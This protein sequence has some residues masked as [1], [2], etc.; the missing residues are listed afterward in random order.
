MPFTR[1]RPNRWDGCFAPGPGRHLEARRTGRVPGPGLS[2]M[3]EAK[4]APTRPLD[5][6]ESEAA[7]TALLRGE[8]LVARESPSNSRPVQFLRAT[9]HCLSSSP[10][11]TRRPPRGVFLSI[12]SLISEHSTEQRQRKEALSEASGSDRF[13]ACYVW[14]SFL[15]ANFPRYTERV[16]ASSNSRS[17]LHEEVEM[18]PGASLVVLFVLWS[19]LQIRGLAEEPAA[20]SKIVSVE[21]S[22]TASPLS[23]GSAGSGAGTYRLDTVPGT[24]AWHVLDQKQ[25]PGGNGAQAAGFRDATGRGRFAGGI[26]RKGSGHSSEGQQGQP[27][28]AVGD[29]RANGPDARGLPRPENQQGR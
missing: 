2:S 17:V 28:R 12:V 21:V 25:L 20:K 9:K 22:R 29:C 18:R 24:G 16:L 6:F 10:R 3:E 15:Q 27:D 11:G 5:P 8:D 1:S 14:R 13:F 7:A 26:G 4:D 23:R 19:S